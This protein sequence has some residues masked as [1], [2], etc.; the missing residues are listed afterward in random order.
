MGR[1]LD[2]PVNVRLEQG[3]PVGFSWQGVFYQVA[4]ILDC[5]KDAGCWWEG[6]STKLFYRVAVSDGGLFE[7]YRDTREDTWFMYKIYD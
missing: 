1:V 5:W 6:E 2:R 7:L 3:Q 4:K